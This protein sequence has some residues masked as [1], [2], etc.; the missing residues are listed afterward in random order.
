MTVPDAPPLQSPAAAGPLA[1]AAR[2]LEGEAA[3]GRLR[4]PRRRLGG[5]GPVAEVD[6]RPVVVFSSND[7]LGLAADS[8]VRRAAAEAAVAEG[9]GSTGSR[10]LSGCHAAIEELEAEICAFEGAP[11]A[12]IAPS[13]YAA[14]VALLQALGGPD[15]VV[16]SDERNHASLIDGCR[17]GRGAVEV[18][19]HRDLH[20]LAHRLAR[21][22]G[23]R[24]VIASDTVFSMDGTVAPVAGLVELAERHGAWLVLD[25]A[26]ATGVLGPGGRGAAAEACVDPRHP[27]VVRTVTLSKGLGAQGA[28]VCGDPAVRQLLLQRGRALIFSTA[29]PHPT[30]AAARAALRVLAE[31]PERV[32]RLR[33]ATAR[34]RTAL[35]PL[36]PSGR[37][38][39]PV[40]PIPAGAEDRAVALEAALLERGMLVQAVRPP[41]VPAGTS[42]LRIAVSAAHTDAHLDALAA[43]LLEVVR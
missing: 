15:A 13:G 38:D 9:V 25:E 8:R 27:Q 12:T 26:H 30:V 3:A 24:P 36:E 42:R 32:D 16:Y 39:I 17:L 1:W 35:A 18:Y 40:L 21:A 34:L 33:R 6:G 41:T 5:S 10:H 7:Y 37:F 4:R 20:D 22:G 2:L 31:E 29:L 28:A 19:R 23:R 43:T 14:N 11:A